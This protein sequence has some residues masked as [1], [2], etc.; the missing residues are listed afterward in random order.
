MIRLFYQKNCPFCKWAFKYIEELKTEYPEFQ[1]LSI[2]A[3]EENENPELADKYDYYY[4]PTFYL[5]EEKIH[6]GGIY[7]EELEALLRGVLNKIE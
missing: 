2:E 6:E 5:G 7:K 4:V 3:I 1:K